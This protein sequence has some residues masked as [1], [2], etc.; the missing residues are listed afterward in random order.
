MGACKRCGRAAG[1]GG[2]LCKQC[3]IASFETK[4]ALTAAPAPA[5]EAAEVSAQ[6]VDVAGEDPSASS[7]RECPYCMAQIPAVARKCMHCGEWVA[8]A[9]PAA[10]STPALT[11]RPAQRPGSVLLPLGVLLLFLGGA[12]LVWAMGMDTTVSASLFSTER[13][14]NIGLMN[15]KQNRLMVAGVIALIGVVMAVAGALKSD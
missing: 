14:H 4:P 13:I 1:F 6:L 2:D 5:S 15:E 12:G 8:S 9:A 3:W 7:E 10:S 11:L